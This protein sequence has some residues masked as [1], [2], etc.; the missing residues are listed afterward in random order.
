MSHQASF[1]APGALWPAW[2]ERTEQARRCRAIL[3]IPTAIETIEDRGITSID[4]RIPARSCPPDRT[5]RT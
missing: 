5:P 4:L 2:R 3:S 1:L